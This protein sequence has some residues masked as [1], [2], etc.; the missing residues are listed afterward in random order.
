MKALKTIGILLLLL[1]VLAFIASLILPKEVSLE[2]SVT[3]NAPAD[4]VWKHISSHEAFDNWS[5]WEKLDTN[6]TKE[7]IGEDGTVG[8]ISKWKSDNR[9]VGN[10]EQE[11]TV[12]NRDS[13]LVETEV[14]FEGMGSAKSWRRM[15]E[16][17]DGVTVSWGFY[18]STGIPQ[19]LM[20]FVFGVKKM[21]GEQYDEGLASLKEICEADK[22]DEPKKPEK[23]YDVQSGT[24]SSVTYAGIKQLVKMSDMKS[25]IPTNMG[26]IGGALGPKIIGA[27]VTLYFT[28]DEENGESEMAVAVPIANAD[29][30]GEFEV[31]N[32]DSSNT[33]YIDYYGPYMGMGSAHEWLGYHMGMNKI[34]MSGQPVI[35]QYITDPT[36]EADTS[37]WLTKVIYPIK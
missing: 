31:I 8:A 20:M 36:T 26:K 12:I 27:P 1:V 34:E 33:L 30:A 22:S 23:E 25:F 14:R 18:N 2:R 11:F 9:N 3:I 29:D 6:M 13:G 37:K 21:L 24:I 17:E 35:E 16:G 19:N 32:I 7:I 28:W 15:T 4:V 10:G 5:P